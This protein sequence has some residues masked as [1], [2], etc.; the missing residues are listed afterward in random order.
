MSQAAHAETV[1]RRRR[2]IHGVLVAIDVPEKSAHP[3]VV[4]GIDISS[5]GMG[6]VL[7]DEDFFEG[8][9]VLLSFQLDDGSQFSRMPAV[10]RH[11]MTASGGVEFRQWPAGER[12]KLL[13]YLVRWYE[14]L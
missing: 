7:P 1:R 10:V 5:S 3:W 2:T 13:E 6:L 9:V 12:L 4:D 11:Q 14:T 8:Q